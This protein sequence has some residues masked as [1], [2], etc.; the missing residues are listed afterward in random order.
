MGL[1]TIT[2]WYEIKDESQRSIFDKAIGQYN[3]CVHI[4][5]SR[6]F[7]DNNGLTGQKLQN[8]LSKDLVN[9]NNVEM[10]S[11]KL[12]EYA[13]VDA[14]AIKKRFEGKKVIFGGKLNLQRY[15]KKLISKEEFK[16][17]RIN[18]ITF[19]GASYRHG[20]AFCIINEDKTITV[21][22][23]RNTHITLNL[24]GCKNNKKDRGTWKILN[25][26]AELQK[27]EKCK[28][29]VTF[30][31]DFDQVYITFPNTIFSKSN[32]T[33]KR[34]T[35]R[36][37]SI[38]MNPNY[39]GWSVNDWF[40]SNDGV[41]N[42]RL[43]AH[44]VFDISELN[45][46]DKFIKGKSGKSSLKNKRHNEVCIIAKNL[47]RTASFYK[48]NIIAFEKLE[49]KQNSKN[50]GSK[51]QKPE[52]KRSKKLN[53]LINRNWCR[54]KFKNCFVK[55]LN[56]YGYSLND[57]KNNA[58]TNNIIEVVASYSSVIGNIIYG[59]KYNKKTP[60]PVNSSIEIGRRAYEFYHQ[61]IVKDKNKADIVFP[62]SDKVVEVCTR[63]ME[64]NGIDAKF[65]DWKSMKELFDSKKIERFG[66]KNS[67]DLYRVP[68]DSS[69]KWFKSSSKRSFIYH[70]QKS[71]M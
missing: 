27:E 38:D 2:F 62:V 44:G 31:I 9:Y 1:Q 22:L 18:P 43:I 13:V 23:N 66:Q 63:A 21:K 51:E 10:M 24:I 52:N 56:V 46:K 5:N 61:F 15:Q 53:K 7:D 67:K 68:F 29:C 34:I 4:A 57:K 17:N 50:K 3:N 30:K 32:Y 19:Q 25:K 28:I 11:S 55:W 60:D 70:F 37:F 16:R 45:Q 71:R 65:R 49:F 8:K 42:N 35:N 54:E 47:A 12:R 39:T 69:L 33:P 41:A 40:E 36:T 64:A 6:L 59:D 14:M 26:I 58:T 20:N 48:C